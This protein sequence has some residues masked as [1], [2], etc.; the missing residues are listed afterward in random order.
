MVDLKTG[1]SRDIV[2]ENY[3]SSWFELQCFP[4]ACVLIAP[5]T[6]GSDNLEACEIFSWQK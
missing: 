5:R 6:A 3:R 2:T 4:Q 1:K